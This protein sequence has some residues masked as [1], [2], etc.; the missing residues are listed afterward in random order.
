MVLLGDIYIS[1]DNSKVTV[2]KVTAAWVIAQNCKPWSCALSRQAA[3]KV[4]DF[5]QAPA[6]SP[7]FLVVCVT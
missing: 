7:S 2:W 1:V 6:I 4:E 5:L 3:L